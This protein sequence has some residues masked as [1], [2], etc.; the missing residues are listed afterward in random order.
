MSRGKSKLQ[1]FPRLYF[2]QITLYRTTT[3]EN[4]LT[5]ALGSASTKNGTIRYNSDYSR[6]SPVFSL[7]GQ[8]SGYNYA[9]CNGVYYYIRDVKHNLNGITDLYLREDV[10]MTHA[11]EIR[12][13]TAHITRRVGGQTYLRDTEFSSFGNKRIGIKK[14]PGSLNTNGTF[15]LV[16]AGG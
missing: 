4:Y 3:P 5:K 14:F 11:G 6:L 12:G 7:S 1:L 16:T 2:M 15:I 13:M 8:V 9:Y 10:L